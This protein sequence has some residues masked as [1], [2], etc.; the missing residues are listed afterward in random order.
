MAGKVQVVFQKA[1]KSSKIN[2]DVLKE[3]KNQ[4]EEAPS[5]KIWDIFSKRRIIV[6]YDLK[7]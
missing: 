5:G 2:R 4:L 3:H 6:V 1:N 7:N